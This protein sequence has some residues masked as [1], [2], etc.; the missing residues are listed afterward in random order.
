METE[1]ENSCNNQKESLR[2]S[3]GV[4]SLTDRIWK[5]TVWL[6]YTVLQCPVC[7]AAYLFLNVK[8]NGCYSTLRPV[9]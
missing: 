3:R 6:L 5:Q 2:G 7:I 4:S 8:R 9:L 1:D